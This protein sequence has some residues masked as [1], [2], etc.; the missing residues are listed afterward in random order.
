MTDEE[1]RIAMEEVDKYLQKK[2]DK[3]ARIEAFKGLFV[4]VTTILLIIAAVLMIIYRT[5]NP[6]Y[7]EN[8]IKAILEAQNHYE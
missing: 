6:E 5:K 8:Y 7:P 2:K 1:K 4:F 3:E